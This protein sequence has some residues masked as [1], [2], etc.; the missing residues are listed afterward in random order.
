MSAAVQVFF[1]L[2]FLLGGFT[3]AAITVAIH[4]E[5]ILTGKEWP[6]LFFLL[7]VLAPLIAPAATI[8]G[9]Y[10]LSLS[11]KAAVLAL[12]EIKKQWIEDHK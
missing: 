3:A 7:W 11:V 5:Y 1:I 12:I 2:W 8:Y 9:L 6:G 10:R 4:M